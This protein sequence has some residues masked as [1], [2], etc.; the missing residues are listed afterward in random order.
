MMSSVSSTAARWL[1]PTCLLARSSVLVLVFL[2]ASGARAATLIV[3]DQYPSIAA[4]IAASTPGDSVVIHPGI[5][6]ERLAVAHDLTLMG[7]GSGTIL[8]GEF[9]T[10][11]SL[12]HIFNS[13]RVNLIELTL[14]YGAAP[15]AGAI[16]ADGGT[17]LRLDKIVIDNNGGSCTDGRSGT[18]GVVADRLYATRCQF[19]GNIGGAYGSGALAFDQGELRDCVFAENFSTGHPMCGGGP[20]AVTAFGDCLFERCHFED[21]VGEGPQ[22]LAVHGKATLRD[23]EFTNHRTF[24]FSSS[25]VDLF[26]PAT[27]ERCRF[28]G[29]RN[30]GLPIIEAL[31]SLDLLESTFTNNIW[32][33]MLVLAFGPVRMTGCLMARNENHSGLEAQSTAIIEGCTFADPIG[34]ATGVRAQGELTVRRS[35]FARIRGGAAI[36]CSPGVKNDIDCNDLWDNDVDYLSCDPGPNDI[37]ADPLFCS[38]AGGDYRLN[39]ASPCAPPNSPAECGL[40]GALG[41]GCG[42][43]ASRKALPPGTQGSRSVPTRFGWKQSSSSRVGN[44]G[45]ST[46]SIRLGE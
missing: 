5:Y 45:A 35:I 3:P 16:A 25:V 1:R 38:P 40:I 28:T 11:A 31:D 7:L 26:G 33:G 9:K 17:E 46:S 44:L 34:Y 12:V 37:A 21:N 8:D 6:F 2:L 20:G 30:G 22:A 36:T 24:T 4:A 19:T 42:A 43:L 27:I 13:A 39:A 23:S 15:G 14:R 29:T 18:G 32:S 10:T 41:V